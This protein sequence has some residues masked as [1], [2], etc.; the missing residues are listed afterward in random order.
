MMDK[1]TARYVATLG[2]VLVV[3]MILMVIAVCLAFIVRDKPNQAESVAVAAIAASAT[4]IGAL[5]GYLFS[6]GP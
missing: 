2:S 1:D 6:R 4:A 3:A 5:F